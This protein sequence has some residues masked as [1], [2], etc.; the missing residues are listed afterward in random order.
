MMNIAI[1]T[2]K[3]VEAKD[4][5]SIETQ[6]QMCQNYYIDN[7][8]VTFEIFSDDGYTGANTNRPDFKK[9]NRKIQ[10]NQF[11]ALVC[12]KLDRISRSVLDIADFF[13][14][15]DKTNTKFICVKDNYD[16]STPMGRAMLYFASVFA[17]L[18]R[19]QTAERVTDAMLNLAKR[20]CWTGGPAPTGY[21]IIKKNGKSYLE[22]DNPEFIKDCFNHYLECGSLYSTHKKL[23]EKYS[24]TPVNRENVRRILRLP[25]YVQ[26]DFAVNKYLIEHGWEI[27]NEPNGKG[28]LVYNVTAGTPMAIVSKHEAIIDPQL[29]LKVQEKID[30]RREE[31]FNK[32][33][34]VYWLTGVLKCPY[35]DGY[36]NLSNSASGH[37]YACMNRIR[38]RHKELPKC[39]NN[40]YINSESLE[41]KID[42][43][44]LHY[45]ADN[46]FDKIYE[47]SN[48]KD[49]NE[50]LAKLQKELEKNR[51]KI[52]NLIDKVSVLSNAAARPFLD[53][54]EDLTK[55]NEKIDLEIEDLQLNELEK[56]NS[57][58]NEKYVKENLLRYKIDMEPSQKRIILKNI[59]ESIY[60]DPN[61]DSVKV[62][63]L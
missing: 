22:L 54:I 28:Y 37:Y 53:T 57:E 24:I 58:F 39:I 47:S 46:N 40:R 55:D 19:E 8:D 18:E 59:F 6:I 23:K 60:Y 38:R 42:K 9:L 12:Y 14:L 45:Q 3:S 2:R 1:Y 43:I 26:S 63:F 7:N 29:W 49:E 35:C 17:Q 31:Y 27:I 36:Y 15:L 16:T 48:T 61:N 51:K 52:K 11:D 30:K 34:K 5:V 25:T 44:V 50:T 32:E 33:S 20:G 62:K 10:L 4:S 56:S 41:K 13:E 21:R